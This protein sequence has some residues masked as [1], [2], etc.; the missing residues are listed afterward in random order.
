MTMLDVD[1]IDLDDL[2]TALED[3]SYETSWWLDPR[4]GEVRFHNPDVDGDS[5]DDLDDAGLVF[6]EPED[7]SVG[8]RDMADFVDAVP[9]PRAGDLLARA[10][11]GRGA[12]R[13]FKDTLFEFPELRRQWFAFHDARLRR[14]AIDWLVDQAVISEAT[15]SAA[16]SDWPEPSVASPTDPLA[17]EVALDLRALYGD[18]LVDVL[19][20]GSRARGEA[21][22]ESD[23]DLLV[24]LDSVP[25]RWAEHMRMD[26]VLW[27]HTYRSGIVVTAFPVD[28]ARFDMPDEPFLVRAKADGLRVA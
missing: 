11:E 3:H 9:D 18:R 13:R 27:R 24:V 5:A 4:T 16:R 12:F 28:A 15:A 7:S 20:F 2:C 8:Y 1:A 23:L 14:R 19:I 21:T 26:E 22:D 25:S 6:I 10:I 17:R